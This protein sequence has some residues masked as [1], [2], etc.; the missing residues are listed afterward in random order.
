MAAITSAQSGN[1]S[2]GSSWV[3]GVPPGNGDSYIVANGHTITV[4]VNTTVGTSPAATGTDAIT[5]Q[6][7]GNMNIAAAVALTCRG[8]L[9]I[10]TGSAVTMAAG[11]S[12]IM[13][14]TQA[15][16]PANAKYKIKTGTSH[17]LQGKLICNGTSGSRC[18]VKAHDSGGYANIQSGFIAGGLQAY[19]TDFA[20]LRGDTYGMYLLALDG[21]GKITLEDCTIDNC[22]MVRILHYNAAASDGVVE[23][24]RTTWSNSQVTSLYLY[25]DANDYTSVTLTD[26]V[27]DALATIISAN[28]VSVDGCVFR[29]GVSSASAGTW[30]VWTNS[31]IR[32]T[33]TTISSCYLFGDL[34]DSYVE[35]VGLSNGHIMQITVGGGVTYKAIRCV[36]QQVGDFGNGEWMPNHA[37]PHT[38]ILEYCI[39]LPYAGS[40]NKN[41]YS[42]GVELLNNADVY[43]GMNHCTCYH[44]GAHVGHELTPTPE[45]ALLYF[46]NSIV[47]SESTA[48]GGFMVLDLQDSSPNVT[49]A[50]NIRNNCHFGLAATYPDLKCSGGAPGANDV[51]VDPQ[52]VDATRNI[53]TW[54]EA[55]G[56]VSPDYD[57][58]WDAM[59]DPDT[60]AW[61]TPAA[62]VAYVR[63]GFAPTNATL[64]NAGDDAVTMGAVEG[65]FASS[66]ASVFAGVFAGP[67]SAA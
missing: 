18:T 39:M 24:V 7:G 43:K 44:A 14:S 8:D 60:Y 17:Y 34:T 37:N 4:D 62:L 5:V 22:N 38:G 12:L 30:T 64:Q 25:R 40:A 10:A 16:V 11:S 58:V 9:T 19:F 61:A 53:L 48:G 31:A 45:G 27:F 35:Q 1:L 6:T 3:G 15:A 49:D 36:L 65:V 42:V 50:A 57:D 13:D 41:A 23:I 28:N 67:V 20:N 56:L 21:A 29:G 66:G 47:W 32:C 51:N 54:G 63:A 46:K 59:S 26:S 55:N 33:S 52:F 2:L